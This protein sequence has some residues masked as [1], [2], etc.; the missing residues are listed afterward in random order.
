MDKIRKLALALFAL[1]WT[2]LWAGA[3]LSLWE[4]TAS[5]FLALL[6][7]SVITVAVDLF[8]RKMRLGSRGKVATAVVVMGLLLL[9]FS[10]AVQTIPSGG[11][12][13]SICNRNGCSEVYQFKSMT[14][15]LW[16][17]GAS[18]QYAPPPVSD[19]AFGINMGCIEFL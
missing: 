11:S 18:Y 8:N 1:A 13:A 10:P 17:W 5:I 19:L 16:C 2:V 9:F 12:T 14:N 4:S 3:I 15:S 6:L 7:L